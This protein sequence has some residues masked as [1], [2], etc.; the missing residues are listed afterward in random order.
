MCRKKFDNIFAQH[1]MQNVIKTFTNAMPI[2]IRQ[3]RDAVLAQREKLTGKA[4][5]H[6]EIACRLTPST[7]SQR[8]NMDYLRLDDSDSESSSEISETDSSDT[9]YE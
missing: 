1:A 2:D 5:Q 9:E 7:R 3:K 8:R 6:S 4:G